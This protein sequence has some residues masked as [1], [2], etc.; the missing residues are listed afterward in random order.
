MTTNIPMYTAIHYD[1]RNGYM[2]TWYA[3]GTANAYKV[4][5]TFYTPNRL[6][7]EYNAMPCGMRDIYGKEMYQVTV[8]EKMEYT[9]RSRHRGPQN[10]LAECDIE[11][12]NRWLQ[13]TYKHIDELRYNVND[14][15]ICFLDIEVA[16]T[17]RFPTADR[18]ERPVNCVTIYISKEKKYYVFGL[19]RD[20][21]EETYQKFIDNDLDVVYKSCRTEY[22]L[23]T[24]LFTKIGQSNID[25]ITGWNS[26]WYDNPYLINRSKLLNVDITLLSRM[27]QG[28]R[29]VYMNERTGILYIAGTEVI[30]YLKLFRKFTFGERDSYK[31]DD[32][33][34]D[35]VGERKAPLP[36]G[37]QSYRNYW[38]E[39]VF[40]NIKDV[41]L[42]VGIDQKKRMIETAI[43]AC[44]E[45]RVPLSSIFE[46]KK[47][48]VGF[49]LNYLHKRGITFPPLQENEAEKFPGAY[50]YSTPGY[51]E[52]L[53]SYDYRSMYPSIMMG[54]NISPET[55][56]QYPIDYVVPEEELKNLVRSPWTHNG[57]KQVFYRRDVEGIVPAV[58]RVLF[59]GRVDFKNM[60][61]DCQR[62]N[63]IQGSEYYNMK[64]LAY[65]LFG[66]SLYGLL[67]NPYFQLYDVDNSASVTTLGVDL[68]TRT[69]KRL[70]TYMETDF[71]DDPRYINTFG[72]KPTLNPELF[73]T[74]LDEEQL[75]C[76]R[77]LSHGD[78]DS[79][80]VKY[81]DIY[82]PFKDKV[83]K[84]V[85]VCVFIDGELKYKKGYSLATD[86]LTSK[87]DFNR[88]LIKVAGS[89]W[90]NASAEDKQKVFIDGYY[91]HT[92]EGREYRII[93]NRFG[94]TDY[95]RMLDT[96]I[97]ESKLAEIMTEYA[98]H[99]N[100]KENTLFL[101]RE[102][103]IHQA[104]VAAKKKYICYVESNEDI[105]YKE[106]KFAI[107]GLEIVRS[108]TTPF[109]RKYLLQLTA[110]LLR[111]RNKLDIRARYMTIKREFFNVT[112]TDNPYEISIP[113]GISSDPP[114]YTDMVNWPEDIRKKVDWRLR[115]GSVWNYLIESDPELKSMTLEPIFASSKVKFLKVMPNIYGLS[116]IAYVGNQC[117]K[118]IYD[119]FMVDWREQW[120]KTFGKT[121]SRLFGAIG[122]SIDFEADKR[123]IMVKMM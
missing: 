78:T 28:Y 27:P 50:V 62:N 122:W 34:F 96:C 20:L 89:A 100:Y 70:T 30:D 25:V 103:C 86:E 33:G 108:S 57:T 10:T 22:D 102:K 2:F 68:I 48:L 91:K 87:K 41:E 85:E 84:N 64:Q 59:D 42:N 77:R 99:W 24:D 37:Y 51:Y 35:I 65:K 95:C 15:N 88:V 114:K 47:M 7:N 4:Q 44:S 49:I 61:K 80:F 81:E 17:D 23:L 92:I 43:G 93:Y 110:D 39:Y 74:Y 8:P 1:K 111:D 29:Q 45:A 32:V 121:M 53:V 120:W 82:S 117:P 109:S 36:D 119:Y 115:A 52:W 105:K 73:G 60:M 58:V 12:K 21:K 13:N 75:E 98:Q 107:T 94:L 112:R 113:S 11:F 56:V 5:H 83:G 97:M 90:E 71:V 14:F 38:D 26:D 123:D 67:G 104:I 16:T 19:N 40:Y 63:D 9:I 116:T 18:A 79:F 54:A 31:L 66:N 46:S 106:L 6:S 69:I 76:T 3:D 55:K 118:R 101:K 72:H